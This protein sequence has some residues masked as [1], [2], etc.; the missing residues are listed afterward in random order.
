MSEVS[1]VAFKA[2]DISGF[3]DTLCDSENSG[4]SGILKDKIPSFLNQAI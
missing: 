1:V 4:N 2:V 3:G